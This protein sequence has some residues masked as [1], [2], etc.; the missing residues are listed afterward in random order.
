M[1]GRRGTAELAA[2]PTEARGERY[3]LCLAS[4]DSLTGEELRRLLEHLPGAGA[5]VLYGERP[6]SY[7][8]LFA[9]MATS[10]VRHLIG[11]RGHTVISELST[12][13]AKI[14]DRDIF[15]CEK[16][17][18]GQGG[19][20][21]SFEVRDSAEVAGVMDKA[22]SYARDRGVVPR[23][24]AGFATVAGELLTNALYNAPMDER[25]GRPFARRSRREAVVLPARQAVSVTFA[26]D[27]PRIAVAVRDRFGTLESEQVIGY[28]AKCFRKGED[29]VE[30]KPGGAGLGFYV[31]F[32]ALSSLV[33]NLRAGELTEII[34]VLDITDSF[35]EFSARSK[36][37][38]VFEG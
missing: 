7:V 25:G 23:L 27:P 37:L 29:Q 21:V 8:E 31:S 6:A 5:T 10:G 34:G 28:L 17:L 13:V 32:Q 3:E 38:C 1:V 15:G 19:G 22:R 14:F 16:Y 36:S 30:K 9:V 12:T 35:K 33:A 18:A 2:V 24:A 4:H 20:I 11:G 26:G